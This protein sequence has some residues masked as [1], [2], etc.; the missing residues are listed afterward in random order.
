MWPHD[1]VL[2]PRWRYPSVAYANCCTEF[3]HQDDI[4]GQLGIRKAI[5]VQAS[6]LKFLFEDTDLNLGVL[7]CACLA[8]TQLLIQYTLRQG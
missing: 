7:D 5:I 1:N 6:F 2:F 3:C 8:D 4:L